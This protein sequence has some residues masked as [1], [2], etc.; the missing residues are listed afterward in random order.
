MLSQMQ[1]RLRNR[2]KKKGGEKDKEVHS[3]SIDGNSLDMKVYN[4]DLIL[5]RNPFLNIGN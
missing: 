2:I 1:S 3:N 5:N 4:I